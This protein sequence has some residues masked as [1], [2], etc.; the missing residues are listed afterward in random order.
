MILGLMQPYFF[1]YLEHFRLVAACDQWVI[2][3]TVLFRRKS[4]MSRNRIINR[5]TKWSYLSV[6]VAKRASL[7]P[8][9]AARF[10]TDSWRTGV[11]RR[12][13][14][15]A[16]EAPFYVDICALVDEIL[17]PDHVTFADLN[18]WGLRVICRHFGISTRI[19]RLSELG[20]D[21]PKRAAAGEWGLLVSKALGAAEYRNASGGRGLFD[22][23]QFEAEGIRL[24][25]HEH[26]P[27]RYETGTFMPIPDLSIIDP[28]MWCGCDSVSGWI[29]NLCPSG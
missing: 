26:R 16:G 23:T 25:F 4:W 20:L 29:R 21:L 12:L 28:L 11:K 13:T 1:P 9:F 19:E 17:A 6:P 18:A 10:G 2:F 3:D 7:N 15:Y 14:V 27:V 5:D 22:A 8:V 24:S